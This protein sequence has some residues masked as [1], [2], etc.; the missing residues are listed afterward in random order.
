MN[1][2][3]GSNSATYCSVSQASVQEWNVRMK[4]HSEKTYWVTDYVLGSAV[5][6]VCMLG[7]LNWSLTC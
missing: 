2:Y 1:P 3:S 4:I 6:V 5:M 7:R